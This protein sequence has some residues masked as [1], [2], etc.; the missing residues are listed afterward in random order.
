MTTRR[1]GADVSDKFGPYSLEELLGAAPVSPTAK[2]L[3]REA[4]ADRRSAGRT[5]PRMALRLVTFPVRVVKRV[6]RLP[7]RA[8][9]AARRSPRS[10]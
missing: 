5:A 3:K 2:Q 4:R 8:V 9:G 6:V 10:S 1:R 7:F